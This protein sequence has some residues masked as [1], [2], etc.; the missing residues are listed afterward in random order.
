MKFSDGG[1]P[2]TYPSS[3]VRRPD[4]KYGTPS[5]VP[6]I[7]SPL[8]MPELRTRARAEGEAVRAQMLETLKSITPEGNPFASLRRIGAEAVGWTKCR[9]AEE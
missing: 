3:C 9:T 2:L 7:W 5:H 4:R 8:G 6:Q 1:A